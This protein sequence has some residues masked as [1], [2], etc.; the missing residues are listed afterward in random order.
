M[1]GTRKLFDKHIAACGADADCP[2]IAWTL[3]NRLME[4]APDVLAWFHKTATSRDAFLMG[5]SGYGYNYPALLSKE[6]Q[7]LH[8][9]NTVNA[10]HQ[11]GW[12][13]YVHWDWAG[14]STKHYFNALEE[15]SEHFGSFLDTVLFQSVPADIVPHTLTPTLVEGAQGSVAVVK[16]AMTWGEGIVTYYHDVDKAANHLKNLKLG[17]VTFGYL[18]CAQTTY[19]EI[20]A[21]AAALAG[22]HVQLVDYRALHGLV[23]QKMA[24]EILV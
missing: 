5:P 20:E 10:S 17:T 9:R 11:L 8:A 1:D 15:E 2:P 7:V 4:Y 6:D 16:Q 19:D 24:H 12:P 13:G 23:S 21:L 3:S 22:S 18:I 14:T